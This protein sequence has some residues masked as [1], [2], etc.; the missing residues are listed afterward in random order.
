[1]KEEPAKHYDF[2]SQPAL[3]YEEPPKIVFHKQE[4]ITCLSELIAV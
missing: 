1:M 2:E 3:I 4:K